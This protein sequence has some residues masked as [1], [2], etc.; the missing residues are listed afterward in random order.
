MLKMRYKQYYEAAGP[1]HGLG[2]LV[3]EFRIYFVRPKSRVPAERS[4]IRVEM[5]PQGVSG[6]PMTHGR[7]CFDREILWGCL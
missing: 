3:G 7:W 1:N 2:L 4:P 6:E 5:D